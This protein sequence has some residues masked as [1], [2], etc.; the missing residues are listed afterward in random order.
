MQRTRRSQ[1]AEHAPHAVAAVLRDHGIPLIKQVVERRLARLHLRARL[2]SVGPSPSSERRSKTGSDAGTTEEGGA[3]REGV[4]QSRR[5]WR[6]PIRVTLG[7]RTGGGGGEE[8]RAAGGSSADNSGAAIPGCCP[9]RRAEREERGGE[10]EHRSSKLELAEPAREIDTVPSAYE[11][12]IVSY[13]AVVQRGAKTRA[14]LRFFLRIYSR[15]GVRTAP[16]LHRCTRLT[17]HRG[18]GKR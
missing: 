16:V 17:R 3:A 7:R 10:D 11:S 1:L 15:T 13:T 8:T 2:I 9:R 5:R 6:A 14:N 12:R 18:W 4:G